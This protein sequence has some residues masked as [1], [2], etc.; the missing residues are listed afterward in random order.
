MNEAHCTINKVI[1]S[2]DTSGIAYAVMGVATM[3]DK[4]NAADIRLCSSVM[5]VHC[6]LNPTRNKVEQREVA[7]PSEY[8]IANRVGSPARSS[9]NDPKEDREMRIPSA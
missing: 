8:R 1:I 6:L 4:Y 7:F 3:Q 9:A 5:L 2:Q